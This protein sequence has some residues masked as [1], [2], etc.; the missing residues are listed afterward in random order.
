[1]DGIDNTLNYLLRKIDKTELS[2]R[3]PWESERTALK[4]ANIAGLGPLFR[5]STIPNPNPNPE[6][7]YNHNPNSPQP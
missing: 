1:M 7:N 6:P 3:K 2:T 4:S 5:G